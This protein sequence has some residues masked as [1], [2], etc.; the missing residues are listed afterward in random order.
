MSS[1]HESSNSAAE[2]MLGAVPGEVALGRGPVPD[3]GFSRHEYD[4][5]AAGWGR[6]AASRA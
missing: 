6:R 2:R 4:H 3:S 5:P 1:R